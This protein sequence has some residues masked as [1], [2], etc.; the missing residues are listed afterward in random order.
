[1]HDSG[2][3]PGEFC[4]PDRLSGS[5]NHCG[6]VPAVNHVAIVINYVQSWIVFPF[7]SQ[8]LIDV[9]LKRSFA[10][11]ALKTRAESTLIS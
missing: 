6:A 8:L 9:P 3:D 1:M 4:N 2:L 5:R 10:Q 11:F 7:A